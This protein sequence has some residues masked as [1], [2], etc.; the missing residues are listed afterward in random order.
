MR[1]NNY[2]PWMNL[3]LAMDLWRLVGVVGGCS[4]LVGLRAWAS[5]GHVAH[6]WR[7]LGRGN[8]GRMQGRGERDRISIRLIGS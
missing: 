7:P 8:I 5:D 6:A 2:S 4:T 3:Q 1:N